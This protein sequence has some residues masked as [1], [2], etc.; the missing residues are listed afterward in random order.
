[1]YWKMRLK[2][3]FLLALGF[4]LSTSCI[5]SVATFDTLSIFLHRQPY[6]LLNWILNLELVVWATMVAIGLGLVLKGMWDQKKLKT[7]HNHQK[8]SPKGRAEREQPKMEG[9]TDEGW[10]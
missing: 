6:E 9:Q 10:S 7:V 3:W 2:G 1:M 5:I 8:P 4:F